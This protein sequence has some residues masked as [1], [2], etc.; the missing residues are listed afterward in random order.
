ATDGLPGGG[1]A[2]GA[3]Q[4]H[5]GSDGGTGM[6]SGSVGRL[7]QG[8]AFG[9]SRPMGAGLGPPAADQ[10][11][12]P[13]TGETLV[14]PIPS[15][16]GVRSGSAG[17]GAIAAAPGSILAEPPGDRPSP[18]ATSAARRGDPSHETGPAVSA[19]PAANE[20]S[21]SASRPI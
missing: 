16:R 19:Q 18:L 3:T 2:V 5:Q 20:G 17:D 9:A 4:P 14:L 1:N 8:V 21:W 7:A 10:V 15:A 11:G 12:D 6:G 13:G